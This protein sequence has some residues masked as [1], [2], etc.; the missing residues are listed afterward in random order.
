MADQDPPRHGWPDEYVQRYRQAGYW[1]GETFGAMLRSRAAQHP[2]RLAV[3]GGAQRLSYGE[4]DRH[5]SAIAT[6]LLA[7]GL[8]AGDRVIVHLPNIPEFITIIFGLFR[9]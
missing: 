2:D 5:A 3:V 9:A 6:G 1:R 8:K 7:Q 4:L